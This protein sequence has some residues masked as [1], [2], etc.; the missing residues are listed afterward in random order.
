MERGTVMNGKSESTG[1]SRAHKLLPFPQASAT[2]VAFMLAWIANQCSR[3][4]FRDEPAPGVVWTAAAGADAGGDGTTL[5]HI[6]SGRNDVYGAD[7]RGG[8]V[9]RRR[10]HALKNLTI[11]VHEGPPTR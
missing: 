9:V 8:A 3:F 2:E 10:L 7:T 5:L 1:T 4:A 6:F 11:Y